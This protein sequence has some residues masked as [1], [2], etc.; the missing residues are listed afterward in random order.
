MFT[1]VHDTIIEL[2]AALTRGC[3]KIAS[4]PGPKI[5]GAEL[6]F[7]VTTCA[8]PCAPLEELFVASDVLLLLIP[9]GCVVFCCGAVPI[10]L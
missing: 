1:L 2:P 6:E 8:E 7:P 5:S 4:E 3:T 10:E 9:D